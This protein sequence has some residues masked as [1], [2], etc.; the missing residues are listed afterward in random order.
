MFFTWKLDVAR[1][2]KREEEAKA[3]AAENPDKIDQQT[4]K[5]AQ[6]QL[7]EEEKSSLK[8]RKHSIYRDYFH[9]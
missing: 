4:K 8:V 3:A 9:Y 2:Q 1:L 7:A 6:A 5:E